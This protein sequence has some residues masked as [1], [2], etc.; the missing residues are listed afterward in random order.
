MEIPL[1][2]AARAVELT[3]L[4][5]QDRPVDRFKWLDLPVT[6][7][8]EIGFNWGDCKHVKRG[9]TQEEILGVLQEMDPRRF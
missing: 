3:F 6:I 1:D 9:I 4:E 2:F 5:L 8:V 7:D